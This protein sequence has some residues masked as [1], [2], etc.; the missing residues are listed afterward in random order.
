MEQRFVRGDPDALREMYGAFGGMIHRIGVLALHD[1]HDAEDLV[2]QV[3]VKAW[4]GRGTFDPDRGSL[5]SWLLGITRHQIADG[6]AERSRHL[7]D[8]QAVAST[9]GP[10]ENNRAAE[11]LVDRLAMDESF[12]RLPA[13]QQHVLRLAFYDGLTHVE[14]ADV[15]GWPVGTVKSHIRRG[16]ARLRQEWE[17]DGAT[18]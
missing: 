12:E 5:V 4:R 3:F 11:H 10:I 8:V 1:H 18:S 14:I 16:L 7:R 15:T 6:F 2:Q 13:V 9:S 17:V